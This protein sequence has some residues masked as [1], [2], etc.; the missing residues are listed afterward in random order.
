MKEVLIQSES[1]QLDQFLKWEG[2]AQTGGH[3]KLLITEGI[4]TVN[5]EKE[6]RRSRK[7]IVG[8]EIFVRDFGLYKIVKE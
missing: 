6:V 3:A 4:I 8:D 2:I 1:I 5:G 7:L